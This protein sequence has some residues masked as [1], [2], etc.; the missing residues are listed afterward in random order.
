MTPERIAAVVLLWARLYTRRLPD[1]DARRRVDELCADVHDHISHERAHGTRERRI[2]GSIAARMLRGMA[3]DVSWQHERTRQCQTEE[4]HPMRP[5]APARRSVTRVAVIT[6]LLLLI[7]L[8]R[9]LLGEGIDW[10]VF[11]FVLAGAIIAGAGL[12]IELTVRSRG[13]TAYAAAAVAGTLGV[14]AM[15]AGE[16]DDAPGLVGFGLLLLLSMVALTVRNA[17]IARRDT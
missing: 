9:T 11:D 1:Q 16:A 7:P 8:A 4:D 6:V 14:G 15:V 13:T 10:G 2:A 12:L 3:A 5:T 17:L